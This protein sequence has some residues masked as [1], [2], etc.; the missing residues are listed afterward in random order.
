MPS[1]VTIMP[2]LLF[3]LAK[4]SMTQDIVLKILPG[5]SQKNLTAYE[6][7]NDQLIANSEAALNVTLSG[8]DFEEDREER[9]FLQTYQTI[10]NTNVVLT[11]STA[12]VSCVAAMNS[13]V[14]CTGR[15]RRK[16]SFVKKQT[17]DSSSEAIELDSSSIAGSDGTVDVTDGNPRGRAAFTIWTA[18]ATTTTITTIFTD[19]STTVSLSYFCSVGFLTVPGNSCVG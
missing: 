6:S 9:F 19:S 1:Y 7:E 11:T 8:K 13:A 12:F 3:L 18:V 16:R 14:D 5:P 17:A 2:A 10:T 15:K 4:Q